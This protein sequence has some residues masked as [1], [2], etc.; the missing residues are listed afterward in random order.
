MGEDQV[1]HHER[2]RCSVRGAV[3]RDTDWNRVT[4]PD[5]LD[6]RR[7]NSRNLKG[8]L[9]VFAVLLVG[10]TT[11]IVVVSVGNGPDNDQP[12]SMAVAACAFYAERSVK[13]RLSFPATYDRHSM[14]TATYQRDF[15]TV[16]KNA[17]GG[18]AVNSAIAFGAKNAFGVQS[19]YLAAYTGDVSADGDCIDVAVSDFV[20]Y[21]R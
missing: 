2:T 1:V 19:D 5:C 11:C 9:I 4:C 8:C 13:Q 20:P 6:K 15:A 3:L 18:W 14:E 7:Q 21:A 17:K 16:T 10:M 12:D